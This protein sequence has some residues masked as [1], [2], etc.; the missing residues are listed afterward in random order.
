M[1]IHLCLS[2]P[3]SSGGFPRLWK[4]DPRPL[5][6]RPGQGVPRARSPVLVLTLVPAALP[7]LL[8]VCHLLERTPTPLRGR[9]S[10]Q[11]P[12]R[13]CNSVD[14]DKEKRRE[15]GSPGAEG[16]FGF[17]G[18]AWIRRGATWEQA[19]HRPRKPLGQDGRSR[20]AQVLLGHSSCLCE[21][22]GDQGT[23]S[24]KSQ[25]DKEVAATHVRPW[26]V[27][28]ASL[29]SS[30]QLPGGALSAGREPG[31]WGWAGGSA[32]VVPTHRLCCVTLPSWARA[33]TECLM[34]AD[35]R[36]PVAALPADSRASW[37]GPPVPGFL[38]GQC[39]R[40][41]WCPICLAG[42]RELLEQGG[43]REAAVASPTPIR[44]RPPAAQALR[45][46][47][48]CSAAEAHCSPAAWAGAG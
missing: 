17:Q 28:E 13:G 5:P 20:S 30:A 8:P 47:R 2:L 1:A 38:P 45:S 34:I 11:A 42:R 15:A 23:I 31:G 44:T 29:H 46:S 10:P 40:T 35:A 33:H 7:F 18:S 32:A 39:R 22:L 21:L 12:S 6:G 14:G 43:P 48:P 26:V 16:S 4:Q 25:A 41:P 3:V 27:P 9:G 36:R 24:A 37:H 19:G